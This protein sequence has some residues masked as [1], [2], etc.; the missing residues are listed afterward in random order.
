MLEWGIHQTEHPVA[1]RV[2]A[3]GVLSRG[4]EPEKDYGKLL[5]RYEVAHCGGQV[6]VLGLG[7]F[8]RLG[9]EVVGN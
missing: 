4:I 3:N 5:N 9:E 6:A 2:P 7:S 8:F 1:I